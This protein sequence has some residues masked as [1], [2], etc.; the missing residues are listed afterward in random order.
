MDAVPPALAR[1]S[2]MGN[3]V[4]GIGRNALTPVMQREDAMREWERRQSGKAQPPSQ[5]YPQLEYLQQQA[6]LAAASGMN[7]AQASSSA[8]R[9]IPSNLAFQ[10][11]PTALND[12][13]RTNATIRDAVMSSVRSA[14][15]QDPSN[16]LSQAGVISTP[17][18]AYTS[19][20]TTTGNR[21]ATTYQQPPTSYDPPA[22]D[23]RNEPSSLYMPV[24][25]QQYQSYGTA[26]TSPQGS[27]QQS[28]QQGMATR[29]NIVP[30]AS[31][32]NPSFYGAG[33]VPSGAPFPGQAS[34]NL[35]Q[36]PV[37]DAKRISGMDV[38]QR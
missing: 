3:D 21:Y 32:M 10:S 18:Q 13:D 8:A 25:S 26:A 22:F 20:S 16:S 1:L 36:G 30:P 28:A 29:H 7:W 2:Q 37:K 15:R 11:Q 17:P 38:W 9:Y 14:A 24:Q 4:S 33:V 31:S 35:P 19:N 6:E 27:Q 34:P 23:V 5:T 12:H